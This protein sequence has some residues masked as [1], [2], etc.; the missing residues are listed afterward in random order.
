MNTSYVKLDFTRFYMVLGSVYVNFNKLIMHNYLGFLVLCKLECIITWVSSL[1]ND[2]HIDAFR[3][4]CK[5]RLIDGRL[6]LHFSQ[7][8]ETKQIQ[9]PRMQH[10]SDESGENGAKI[11]N[12]NKEKCVLEI[13][14]LK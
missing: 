11:L 6:C 3:M 10:G 4:N 1:N 13:L 2:Y 14:D 8:Y 7:A 5:V 9:L 12:F